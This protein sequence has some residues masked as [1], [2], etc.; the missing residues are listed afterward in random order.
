MHYVDPSLDLMFEKYDK[1]K[2]T[3]AQ[4]T[5]G[6]GTAESVALSAAPKYRP[7]LT[8]TVPRVAPDMATAKINGGSPAQG[9]PAQWK[10]QHNTVGGSCGVKQKSLLTRANHQGGNGSISRLTHQGGTVQ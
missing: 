1:D 4:R 7:L 3:G 6:D 5:C 10:H 8:G 2:F 9:E